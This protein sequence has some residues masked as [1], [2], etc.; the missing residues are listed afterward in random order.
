MRFLNFCVFILVSVNCLT[1]TN[2]AFEFSPQITVKIGSD[3]LQNAWAGGINF[4]QF[5]ELD[6]DLDGDKDIAVFDRSC[7][8]F[9]VYLK[10]SPNRY[11][12][13]N[14]ELD[15]FPQDIRYRAA[16]VDYNGDGQND[17]FCYGL[18]G[19]KVY[20]NTSLTT[21]NLSWTLAKEIVESDY[22]GDLSNLYITSADIPAYTDIEGDGDIDVL[23]FN[24]NGDRLEYHKNLSQETYGHSDS[25]IFELKNECWGQFR[26]DMNNNS[27]LLNNT[28][29]PCG[30][31]N[32]PNPERPAN[33]PQLPK[34]SGSTVLALD[35]NGDGVKDLILGD[36]SYANL[37]S[38]INGG[39]TPNSNSAMTSFDNNYP[40][41]STPANINIFP[42]AYYL[43]VDFDGKK[44][45]IV[46]PNARSVSE[47]QN[48]VWYYKNTGSNSVPNFQYQSDNF[49]QSEMIDHGLGSIPVL[50][51]QN[52]DGLNDL[53]VAN[54][55]RYKPLLEKESCLLAYRNTGNASSPTYTY[56]SNNYLDFLSQNLGLRAVPAFGDIDGDG[57]QDMIV[58]RDNGTLSLFSNIAGSGN[59]MAFGSPTV[60]Q[61]ATSTAINVSAF[62]FPQLFD[63]DKD[64]LLDLL[65]GNKVGRI[66]YYKNIG[67]ANA[68]SYQLID[69]SLGGVQLAANPDGYASPHFF[70]VNDTTHLFLGGNDGHLHYFKDIDENLDPD[71]SFT[72]V[73]DSYLN[74]DVG[75][76]S[77]FW[78]EDVDNDGILNMFIGQDLGGLHH[79]EV[80]PNSTA[81]LEEKQ[82][83]QLLIYPNPGNGVFTIGGTNSQPLNYRI[84][85]LEGREVKVGKDYV[86][87][88]SD[89]NSGTYIIAISIEERLETHRVIKF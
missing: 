36:V 25:L 37:T 42:A 67:T 10:E 7:D 3:T 26:E 1:Q 89:L 5:S 30:S 63:L 78:V 8:R 85:D 51:D 21:G 29:F 38:L 73:S 50:V 40:S 11:V 32:L 77:S 13:H 31:G 4:S 59:P 35:L 43:D 24:S 88:I 58:G 22:Y 74:I 15:D 83:N 69:N 2:F 33:E 75:L 45:L 18:G 39:A 76:Y 65:I 49:L 19:L 66:A 28:E 17:I 68:P 16:F 47:N 64:G 41:N 86:F 48:S 34:H 70:R 62:A 27:I 57:D 55:F 79:Y 82:E 12:Y 84:Y 54:F 56:L 61:D 20:K 23:T 52:G 46:T 9:L 87:D 6:F 14:V 71:S 60:L 81:S 80:N 44:D 72:L 53:L